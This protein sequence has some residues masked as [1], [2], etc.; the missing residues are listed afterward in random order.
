MIDHSLLKPELTVDEV[1]KGCEVAK[2]IWCC[3]R[4]LFT[5]GVAFSGDAAERDGYKA[6]DGNWLSAGL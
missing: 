5:F 1:R 4:L 6:D 2:K 3:E